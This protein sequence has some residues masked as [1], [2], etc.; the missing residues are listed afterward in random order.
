MKSSDGPEPSS[1][2]GYS[3]TWNARRSYNLLRLSLSHP[4]AFPLIQS[5]DND[6][7]MEID[8]EETEAVSTPPVDPPKDGAAMN[9]GSLVSEKELKK[10]TAS[11][12]QGPEP[13]ALAS[14]TDLDDTPNIESPTLGLLE[15]A[16]NDLPAL[17]ITAIPEVAPL[18]SLTHSHSPKAT[19][20][21]TK[22]G[23]VFGLPPLAED[24][25]GPN[26]AMVP[27]REKAGSSLYSAKSLPTPSSRDRLAASLQKGLQ[28]LDNHQSSLATVRR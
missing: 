13:R 22:D 10:S 24:E 28:I 14:G 4:V 26:F 8:D 5:E 25:I 17:A 11:S 27:F 1:G 16:K 7:E 15:N 18:H 21:Q 23:P 9:M 3:N 19:G 20:D 2:G 12:S 6:E